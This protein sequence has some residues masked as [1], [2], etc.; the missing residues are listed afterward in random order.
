MHDFRNFVLNNCIVIFDVEHVC[1]NL[2][3][4]NFKNKQVTAKPKPPKSSK[5]KIAAAI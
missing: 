5:H 3:V 4:P 2:Q 1:L